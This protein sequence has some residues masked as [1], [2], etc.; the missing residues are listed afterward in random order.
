MSELSGG[1][2]ARVCFASITCRKPEILI[3][4]EPT[5][6]LDIESVQ[7]LIDA[8]K[9]YAGG[10]LL[11]SHDAR[12]IQSTECDIWVCRGGGEL[13]D[14]GK[15]FDEYRKEVQKNL[16]RRQAAAEAEAVRRIEAR[17][18]SR[19]AMLKHRSRQIAS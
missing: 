3:L 5:N 17:R 13:L 1:Q 7:A 15:S 4:D 9:K 14:R 19:E 12:L 10:F 8:L 16:A 18:R 11:V 6:H 2:K